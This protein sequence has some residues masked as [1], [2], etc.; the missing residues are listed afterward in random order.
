[1]SYV[2]ACEILPE[3]LIREIQRY[4]DGGVLYIPR[5][6]ENLL[7]WGEKSGT[8]NRLAKRNREIVSRYYSGVTVAELSIMYF[9]SEKRIRGIIREY[10][11]AV[12]EENGE[13]KNE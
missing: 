2:N 13:F 12:Q 10:G 11:S 7:S 9:L 3:N 8:R 6:D 4:V 5:K 1:M